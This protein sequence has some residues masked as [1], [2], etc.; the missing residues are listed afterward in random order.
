MTSAPKACLVR[1]LLLPLIPLAAA[2]ALAGCQ[3]P[4]D[5]DGTLDRLE[6]GTLRV[7][8]TVNEPWVQ[9]PGDAPT[10]IEPRLVEDLARELDARIDWTEG[11]EEELV[12]ALDEGR[13]DLVVGGMTDKTQWHK[14]AAMTR[15]Y[16]TT[17]IAVGTTPGST[18]PD[19]FAGQTV[20]VEAGDA[21]GGLVLRKTDARIDTVQALTGRHSLA[22]TDDF[23]LSDLG[24]SPAKRL[25]K[26]NHVMLAA[27]GENAWLVR[28]E[29]H[30][31]GNDDL[32]Q[33]LLEDAAP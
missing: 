11:S 24:L 15:P 28:L 20:V 1:R 29:R 26:A 2:L 8:F 23:L 5:P 14:K 16:V 31:L 17:E 27:R 13:L 30:L 21:A 32:V 10:G 3:Y 25:Q 9:L 4:R 22:A 18:H 12:A 6:G 33:A 19:D 7:G